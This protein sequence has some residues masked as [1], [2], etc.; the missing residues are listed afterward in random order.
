M[1]EYQDSNG[2]QD[3][4]FGALTRERNNCFMVGDVKQSIYQF[5]L[6]DPG[7]FLNKYQSYE[8]AVDAQAGQG[9]KVLL[10]HN[11]RSGPEIIECVNSVF[12]AAMRP[13]VGGL[14][15][16]EAEALREGIPHDPLPD[17][18]VELHVIDVAA[19]TYS[20]E[21]DYV[22]DRITQLLDGKHLVRGEDGLRP[23]R[24]DDIV[25]LLR[26]PKT[27]GWDF[28]YALQKRGLQ[29]V[30]SHSID[31]LSTDEVEWLRSFLQTILNP[32]QDIPLIATITGPVF[33]FTA[34]DLAA[35]RAGKRKS[36]FYDALRQSSAEK[37]KC[38]LSVL[39]QLR[40]FA[41]LHTLAELMENIFFLTR[42]DAVYAAMPD[43]KMRS[44]NL[45]EF[46]QY[47]K[48]GQ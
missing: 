41:R 7:I 33:G 43:G 6:A 26:S 2:V 30:S 10:S 29:T 46:Y 17:G 28:H 32:Q 47:L 25:I 18:N 5:R 38:F 16:G 48:S 11:F 22:A 23:I 9:R 40:D 19:D 42:A 37:V 21:A 39:A 45:Q 20:E 12:R 4:I 24:P 1:D 8:N 44:D 13:K 35:I 27:S 34:N 36:S 14:T 31:L 15:Y 3:A